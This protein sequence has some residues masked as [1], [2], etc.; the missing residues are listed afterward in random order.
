MATYVKPGTRLREKS[1]PTRHI[2]PEVTGAAELAAESATA[3]SVER[4]VDYYG[5]P[6]D[7]QQPS[8]EQPTLAAR[9]VPREDVAEDDKHQYHV[10]QQANAAG[11]QKNSELAHFRQ[12][13]EQQYEC[14]GKANGKYRIDFLN[15]VHL[16]TFWSREILDLEATCIT[17]EERQ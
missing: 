10:N 14:N 11:R 3:E 6:T 2:L 13:D 16:I 15:G 4:Q 12:G 7:K 17:T 5:R 8:P 9:E 1:R